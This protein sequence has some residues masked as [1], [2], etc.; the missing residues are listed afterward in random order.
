MSDVPDL[1]RL[2]RDEEGRAG[3]EAVALGLEWAVMI[4]G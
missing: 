3:K 1:E 4:W 2:E